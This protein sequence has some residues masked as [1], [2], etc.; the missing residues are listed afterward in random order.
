MPGCGP[1]ADSLLQ[2]LE[3]VSSRPTR[4]DFEEAGS[5]GAPQWMAKYCPDQTDTS[6]K[7]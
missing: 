2:I 7:S 1:A 3:K 5:G 6:Q 4:T